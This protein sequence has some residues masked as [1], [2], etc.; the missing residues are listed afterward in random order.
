MLTPKNHNN[1]REM[2][3]MIS[4]T[5][6]TRLKTSTTICA[7]ALLMSLSPAMAKDTL[8]DR[9]LDQAESDDT[10]VIIGER[11]ESGG[12]VEWR[13]V[14][15]ASEDGDGRFEVDWIKLEDMGNASR[16][17]MAPV[18]ELFITDPES[19]QSG[20]FE[21]ISAGLEY[22]L[23]ENGGSVEQKF[24]AS[25][26]TVKD[27]GG[28]FPLSLNLVF[29]DVSGGHIYPDN[30]FKAGTGNLVA[31]AM[32]FDYTITPPEESGRVAVQ[33]NMNDFTVAYSFDASAVIEGEQPDPGAI[34]GNFTMTS[35]DSSSVMDVEVPEAMP[36]NVTTTG[37]G[38]DVRGSMEDGNVAY[39]GAINDVEYLIGLPA[40]GL[41][42]ASVSIDS[43][44]FAV[45]MPIAQ[46][47]E[48]Q[49]M[50]IKLGFNE[51][52][53]DDML[54]AMVDPQ[55]MLPRDAVNV[56]LDILGKARVLTDFGN[57]AGT[58]PG[59][60]PFEVSNAKIN[61]LNIQAVGAQIQGTGDVDITYNGPIPAPVGELN[62]S[63]TGLNGLLDNLAAMGLLQPEQLMPVRMMLPMFTRAVGDDALAST[64]EFKEDGAILAN[65]QRLR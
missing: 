14:V 44:E 26:I 27:V 37:A 57:P 33:S 35:G 24:A 25:S 2:T 21:V 28:E 50:Q 41:P 12:V 19:G 29:S 42:E 64:I 30:N 16:V 32:N 36:F 13:D 60:M 17:T 4:P 5:F 31:N 38:F 9:L 49:D 51:V 3:D 40:L 10:N 8:V 52:L 22:I 55:G 7:T 48:P 61:E 45:A 39:S 56:N 58:A 54:W 15:I 59:Q 20:S 65:G 46:S 63:L 47:D 43:A 6:K 34:T 11:L 62:F 1:V 23:S 18:M 53:V